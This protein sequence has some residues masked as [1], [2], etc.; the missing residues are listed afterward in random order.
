MAS[1]G[2]RCALRYRPKVH[3]TMDLNW[4]YQGDTSASP[5]KWTGLLYRFTASRISSLKTGEWS[6]ER[7]KPYK[8]YNRLHKLHQHTIVWAA[9]NRTHSSPAGH[10]RSEA[11]QKP[12]EIGRISLVFCQRQG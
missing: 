8:R 7:S 6:F 9:H 1:C 2:T 10:G 4:F 3:V 5:I 12:A 11:A